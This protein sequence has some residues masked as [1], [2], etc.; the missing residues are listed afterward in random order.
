[1]ALME[2]GTHPGTT[3]A[4]SIHEA[5]SGAVMCSMIIDINGTQLKGGICLVMKDGSLSERGFRD[6]QAIFGW[7]DW[8]WAKW[9]QEPEAFAGA[10]VQ[11]KV[12]TVQGERGEYSSIKYINPASG[13]QRLEK[14][15]AQGLAARYGAKTRALFGGAPQ[16]PNRPAAAMPSPKPPAAPKPQ[17]PPVEA[18]PT[19]TIEACWNEFCKVN[20]GKSELE[21]YGLWTTQIKDVTGKAQNDCTPEDWGKLFKVLTASLPL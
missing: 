3:V 12:E 6:V 10:P 5:A 20:S 14:A 13:G 19:S 21:L 7:S 16:T 1:M 11:V 9:D 15:N 17:P 2:E 8:D 18:R 4:A